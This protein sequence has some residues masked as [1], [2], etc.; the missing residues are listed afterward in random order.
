MTRYRTVLAGF[1]LA[2][3]AAAA[4]GQSLSYDQFAPKP[5]PPVPTSP[6]NLPPS[7]NPVPGAPDEMIL[8]LL[9]GLAFVARPE[10]VAIHGSTVT[11]GIWL[12]EG[13]LV[14]N[15]VQFRAMVAPYLQRPLSRGKLN[16]LI[17]AIIIHYRNHDRPVVDVIV[18]QQDINSGVVQV[19]LLESRIG[20]I[21]VA[22]NHWFSSEEIRRKFRGQSGDRI[23]ATGM[24]ADL[25]WANQN[26]FHTSDI[27]Y[28]PGKTVGST[29][30]VLQTVDRFPARF[31]VGYEDSGNSQT[32]FDRYLAGV[33]WGDAW[34]A[35]LGQQLNYQYT[36]SRDLSGLRAHAGSYV[37]PLPWWHNT[38]TF[39]GSD[40]RTKG[41]VPPV[42][43]LKGHSYQLSGRYSIPL[44][45]IGELRHS[46]GLGFDYKYN[47]NSLQF[48]DIP[49]S[50]R[51][52]EVKQFVLTYDASLRDARGVTSLGF[53]GYYSPGNWGSHNQDEAF[54]QSHTLATSTYHY[55]N[56]TLARLTRLPYN[57]SLFL[58]G[59]LQVS[60]RNLTPSEQ[61]GLG[62][63]DT[64][65]GYDEREVN[66]DEGYL[67]NV[68][69][70]TPVISLGQKLG[71]TRSVDQLQ[72][73]GFW[74]WGTGRNHTPL[75]GEPASRDLSAVG[76]GLR[77]TITT[78]LSLRADYGFQQVKSRV[79]SHHGGRGNIAI[80]LSY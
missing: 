63:N 47:R 61:F 19:L 53:Q 2:T 41:L 77:D 75:V 36:T 23:S 45:L 24:R 80:V 65:R 52:V 79:D 25:E 35:G 27:V 58:R 54:S 15:P 51:P 70:R 64:V 38:L 49:L 28:Q 72:F 46:V 71:W 8:P 76:I 66:S 48:G 42:I 73:L 26:P 55:F 60:D 11:E 13:L 57:W 67:A 56:L 9:R 33:N 5:I 50:T 21:T 18:P 6:V 78:H 32:G 62:G 69:L 34:H 14:P 44:R 40:V 12:A 68:E 31:Y 30:I 22:G 74:D 1:L 7:T 10:D 43:S 3:G 37:I 39:L 29:D 4:R 16:E 17:T 20:S 59:M